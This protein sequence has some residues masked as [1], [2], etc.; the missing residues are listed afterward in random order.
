M[1][2]LG[3]V[4]YLL[5]AGNFIKSGITGVSLNN[6]LA[7]IAPVKTGYF[8]SIK[9]NFAL[10]NGVAQDIE[11]YSKGDNLNMYIN[12][13]FDILQNYANLRVFGRL[14]KRAS[15]ILGPV[16]NVSFNSLLSSIPGLKMNKNDK[17]GIIKDIN[18][19][20]GVELSDQQYRVFTVKIDGDI[21][22]EK[23][24]KNFRWIE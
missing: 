17:S 13:E 11:V 19:I 21:D 22:K 16:G 2:K 15:N 23:Y 24:V 8:D 7:L 3:S 18:K 12:G 9:G 10:K 4:E 20:P 14:T 6:L 5:K 1:P